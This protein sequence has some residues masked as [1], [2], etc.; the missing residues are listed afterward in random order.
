[1]VSSSRDTLVEYEDVGCLIEHMALKA[2]ELGLGSCYIRGVFH[3]MGPNAKYI[4]KLNLPDGFRPISGLVVGKID[5]DLEGKDHK[6]EI[7]YIE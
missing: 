6:I 1:M 4:E 3:S 5:H 7:S 2:T